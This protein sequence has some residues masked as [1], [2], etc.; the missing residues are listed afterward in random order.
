MDLKSRIEQEQGLDKSLPVQV[1]SYYKL[2]QNGVGPKAVEPLDV[3]AAALDSHRM[4]RQQLVCRASKG[5]LDLLAR[6]PNAKPAPQ[7]LQ[8]GSHASAARQAQFQCQ[9]GRAL[10]AVQVSRLTWTSQLASLVFLS[11]QISSDLQRVA[12]VA[13]NAQ[14][15]RSQ[16]W[17]F[18]RASASPA[19][20]T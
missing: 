5:L 8:I 9:V 18:H 15:V 1:E 4:Q 6:V 2:L 14:H 11:G 17:T 13:S 16:V 19:L 20:S 12:P 7:A 3:K 10:S